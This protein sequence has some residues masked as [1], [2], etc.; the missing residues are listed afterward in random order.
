[1]NNNAVPQTVGSAIASLL[2]GIILPNPFLTADHEISNRTPT[3]ARE[4]QEES[5]GASEQVL[6]V[7]GYEEMTAANCNQFRKAA[8]AA[9]KG[10]T[11]VEIDLSETT[12][13]DCA[14]L[15]ALIAVRNLTHERKGVA[16]LMNPTP[17]VQQML[18]FTRTG[19]L[20]DIINTPE[21]GLLF[22][23]DAHN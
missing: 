19:Q 12:L 22:G 13:I 6:K 11:D 8:C 2:G 23:P 9:W 14:G 16:R 4:V 7:A 3:P 5:I 10:H 21:A 1:M 20:F 18:D 15:G 17:S